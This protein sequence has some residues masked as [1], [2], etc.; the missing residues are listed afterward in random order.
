MHLQFDSNAANNLI[1]STIL[2][3]YDTLY[4]YYKISAGLFKPDC[5]LILFDFRHHKIRKVWMSELT[6]LSETLIL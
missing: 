5:M 2:L 3:S 6:F 1:V 4:S